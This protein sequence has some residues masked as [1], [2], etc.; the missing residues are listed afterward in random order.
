VVVTEVSGNS[1]G[2]EKGIKPGDVIAEVDQDDV[3]TP[4]QVVAKI[5][6]A[7]DA[8]RKSILLLVVDPKGESRF[9]P[10]RIDQG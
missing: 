5:Q 3:K 4:G 7:K 6:A 8:K 2:G 9:V 1:P 10:L